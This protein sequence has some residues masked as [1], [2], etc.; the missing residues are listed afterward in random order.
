MESHR[1]LEI[2]LQYYGIP[3]RIRLNIAV[4]IVMVFV[5]SMDLLHIRLFNLFSINRQKEL[6]ILH[7]GQTK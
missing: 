1:V 5:Y 2:H 4:H 7:N 3:V 6:L